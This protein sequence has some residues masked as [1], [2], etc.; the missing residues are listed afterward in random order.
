M[1]NLV[2]EDYDRSRENFNEKDSFCRQERGNDERAT[3]NPRV[4]SIGISTGLQYP[5]RFG[6][7]T[8]FLE[9]LSCATPSMSGLRYSQ[10]P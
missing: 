3:R 1:Q 8:H 6:Q 5:L 7:T 4:T 2:V 9:R 10:I